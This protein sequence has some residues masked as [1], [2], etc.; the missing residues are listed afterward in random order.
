MNQIGLFFSALKDKNGLL[1]K[2]KRYNLKLNPN[3]S[4]Q[5]YKN[6]TSS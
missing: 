3:M 2:V 4:N 5:L 6:F 1:K